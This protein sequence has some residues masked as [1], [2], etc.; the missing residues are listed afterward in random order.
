MG[1]A[2]G[3]LLGRDVRR[4]HDRILLVAAGYLIERNDWFFSRIKEVMQRSAPYLPRRYLDECDALARAAGMPE[5]EV[6]EINFF[7]EMFHCSGA[8][9]R[10]KASGGE[11]VHARVL[12]Y[13]RDIG[14]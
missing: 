2:H 1:R 5:S 7:P 6:R 3:K 14:L 8:A 13:M 4:M 12:D 9:V 11:V 10:G